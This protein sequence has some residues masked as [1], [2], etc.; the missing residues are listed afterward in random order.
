MRKLVTIATLFIAACSSQQALAQDRW[1]QL[2]SEAHRLTSTFRG[3]AWEQRMLPA[4]N[5]F[6]PDIVAACSPQA[7]A[8]GITSFQAVAAISSTGVV[9]DYLPNPQ[10]PALDCFSKQMVGRKYPAPPE[11]PFYE[12][13]TVNLSAGD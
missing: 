8:A 1:Q 7:K 12:F 3:V 4:H 2:A 11:S 9:T 6:W 13:Y 10:S 5:S